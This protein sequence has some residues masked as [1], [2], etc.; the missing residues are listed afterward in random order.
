MPE[1]GEPLAREF[2]CGLLGLTEVDKPIPLSGRGGCSFAGP[3]EVHVHLGVEAGVPPVSQGAPGVSRGRSG[4]S[5]RL[6]SG[7]WHGDRD[8]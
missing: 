6:D 1:G 7:G 4:G 2:Y 5:L 3:G 8:R